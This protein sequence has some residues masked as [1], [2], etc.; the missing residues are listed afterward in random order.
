M[1]ALLFL[2]SAP[3]PLGRSYCPKNSKAVI[4]RNQSYVAKGWVRITRKKCQK[5]K[6]APMDIGAESLCGH[7][8]AKVVE[9]AVLAV[10]PIALI[11]RQD[12][13]CV[14]VHHEDIA[15]K[16]F[17]ARCGVKIPLVGDQPPSAHGNSFRTGHGKGRILL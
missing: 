1:T 17:S 5:N 4:Q 8:T 16:L 7:G 2:G 3:R 11:L 14:G 13:F 6:K 10:T 9:N 12:A 15:A